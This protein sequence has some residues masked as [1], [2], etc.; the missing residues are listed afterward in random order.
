MIE[1]A[2]SA[3]YAVS[4]TGIMMSAPIP[5]LQIVTIQEMLDGARINL[6]LHEPVTKTMKR[7]AAKDEQAI[8][9]I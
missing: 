5:K 9:E 2:A 3:G 6:P 4:P 7:A 1:W 8:M